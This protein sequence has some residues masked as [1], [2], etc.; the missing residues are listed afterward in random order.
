ME[1][2]TLV[3]FSIIIGAFGA[4]FLLYRQITFWK[5]KGIPYVPP[6]PIF[7]CLAPVLFQRQSLPDLVNEIYYKFEDF[8]YYG[9]MD[10]NTP[11]ILI[12]DPELIKDICVKNFDYNPNHKSFIDERLDPIMSKNVFSLRGERWREVR[13]TLSPSFTASKMKFMFQLVSKCSEDFVK[14]LVD[15]PELTKSMDM[16]DAFTRY[17]NDVIA[18]AA[19]GINVNS[20]TDRNNEF[21]LRGKDATN[22]KGLARS[23]KFI[24]GRICPRI[25][26]LLGYK[27]LSPETNKF[28]SDLMT[29]TVQM[30]NEKGIVRPD[31]IHLLMQAKNNEAGVDI[32]IDDIIAQAF[33]FFLAGFETSSTYMCFLFHLLACHQD[34]QERLRIEINLAIL[35]NDGKISYD[36]LSEIKYMDMVMNEALRLYPPATL[37]DRVCIKKFK[38]PPPMKGYE[39]LTVEPGMIMWIPIFGLHHDEK[40]FPDPEKFDPERFSDENKL[41]INSSTF[42]PFGLGPRKCIGERFALMETKIILA[43]LLQKFTIKPTDKTKEKI[44]FDKK[45][46]NIQCKGG[47]WLNLQQRKEDL[48]G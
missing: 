17:T 21:Y 38:L 26:R 18:T 23:L 46:F 30:R 37:I 43:H 5:N 35:K 13:S 25:M 34:I 9:L 3:I 42:I 45:N 15:N 10:F 1:L 24:F 44:E 29:E 14:Y 33:I 47:T 11:T 22:F 27:F 20:L 36:I 19:F 48:S 16:K 2:I 7:G 31:M 12:K 41:N 28:F 40:Y 39:E 32:S 8:K 4:I 6:I